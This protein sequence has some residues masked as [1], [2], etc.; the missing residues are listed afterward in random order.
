[1]QWLLTG[2]P[3]LRQEPPHRR[4]A[5]NDAEFVLDQLRHHLARPQRERELQLQRVLARH[6]IVHPPHHLAIE[7]RRTPGQRF[8]FQPIPPAAPIARE[9]AVN[10]GSVETENMGENFGALAFLHAFHNAYA[11]LFERLVIQ[12]ASVVLSHT[13][14]E[15]SSILS[16][17]KC[18]NIYALINTQSK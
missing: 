17:K 9:P 18:L 15:S 8:R 5:Q 1:M 11:H 10:S 12:L 6:R 2:D 4:R 7:L 16:V 14:G 13:K 3:E